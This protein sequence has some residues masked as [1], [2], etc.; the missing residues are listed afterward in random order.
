MLSERSE[1]RLVIEGVLL[2]I[3]AIDVDGFQRV[4]I[5][6]GQHVNSLKEYVRECLYITECEPRLPRKSSNSLVVEA[7]KLGFHFQSEL[8]V[9]ELRYSLPARLPPPEPRGICRPDHGG[10]HLQSS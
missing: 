2:V 1:L 3:L 4:L 9:N 10:F 7:Q 6:R 5:S 8:M